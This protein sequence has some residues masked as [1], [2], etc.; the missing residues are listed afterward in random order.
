MEKVPEKKLLAGT[1]AKRIKVRTARDAS[2]ASSVNLLP[3]NDSEY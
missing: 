1:A 2:R 3:I